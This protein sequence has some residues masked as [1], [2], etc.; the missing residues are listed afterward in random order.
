MSQALI[1]CVLAHLN[2]FWAE[3]SSFEGLKVP[4]LIQNWQNRSED[5]HGPASFG[6]HMGGQLPS[7]QIIHDYYF[8]LNFS[9]CLKQTR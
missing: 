2:A 6:L 1:Y 8:Y 7:I 5:A 9:F 3:K 4:I